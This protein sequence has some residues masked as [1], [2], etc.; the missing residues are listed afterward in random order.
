VLLSAVNLIGSRA[1]STVRRRSDSHSGVPARWPDEFHGDEGY[2]YHYCR[3]TLKR[4]GITA[5]I[6]RKDTESRPGSVRIATSSNDV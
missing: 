3:E 4:R 6:A 1:W 2:G 5:R